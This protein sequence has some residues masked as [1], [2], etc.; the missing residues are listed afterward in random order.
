MVHKSQSLGP[1]NKMEK[2]GG[3]RVGV[4]E[5][6]PSVTGMASWAFS[7]F[8]EGAIYTKR[9]KKKRAGHSLNMPFNFLP[10]LPSFTQAHVSPTPLQ[11]KFDLSQ[12]ATSFLLLFLNYL[13]CDL[14][15][16]KSLKEAELSTEWF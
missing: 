10:L 15:P 7:L 11:V 12:E 14:A 9:R 2:S 5:N 6:V 8:G 1:Q 4:K 13:R 3:W 16:W